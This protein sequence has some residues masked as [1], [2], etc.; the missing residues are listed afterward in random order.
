MAD[1]QEQGRGAG[2]SRT[3]NQADLEVRTMHVFVSRALQK[4]MREAPKK[5]TALRQACNDVIGARC[6]HAGLRARRAP[7]AVPCT[8]P[9][10]PCY[11]SALAALPVAPL[12]G[13][14]TARWAAGLGAAS[15]G[16]AARVRAARA[17]PPP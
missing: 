14:R 17:R 16:C 6:A 12:R 13:G 4:I 10:A 1:D 3:A 7:R 9:R 2:P 15:C 5:Q 8:P 11:V